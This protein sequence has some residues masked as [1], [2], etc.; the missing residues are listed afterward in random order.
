[1]P[2]GDPRKQPRPEAVPRP[3]DPAA[4]ITAA[5]PPTFSGVMTQ[6]GAEVVPFPAFVGGR[7]IDI[8]VACGPL[9]LHLHLDP[10]A[11]E[12]V[13]DELRQAKM[14]ADTGIAPASMADVAGVAKANG[15]GR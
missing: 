8:Q 12:S 14:K 2:S 7:A 11:V 4:Q 1:M 13:I 5:F 9:Q 6:M 15:N 10:S 3:V